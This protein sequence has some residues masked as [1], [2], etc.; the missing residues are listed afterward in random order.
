MTVYKM[1]LDDVEITVHDTKVEEMQRKG[2]SLTKKKKKKK[3]KATP[4]VA[5]PEEGATK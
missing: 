5:P 2:F 3:K 4:E 1:Y